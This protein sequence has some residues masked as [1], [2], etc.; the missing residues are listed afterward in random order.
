MDVDIICRH[1][2]RLA[3]FGRNPFISR[4]GDKRKV[5]VFYGIVRDSRGSSLVTTV[6]AIDEINT[7][8]KRPSWG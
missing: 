4:E 8:A 3:Y 7:S 1:I 5:N 6:G 2:P